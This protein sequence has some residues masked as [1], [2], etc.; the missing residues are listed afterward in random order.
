MPPPLPSLRF[1]LMLIDPLRTIQALCVPFLGLHDFLDLHYLCEFAFPP[2]YR[3]P[4]P[5]DYRH[6]EDRVS[7]EITSVASMAH[8][9]ESFNICSMGE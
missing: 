9:Q 3:T 4:P 2:P 6:L 1:F 5:Q 7:F 8:A